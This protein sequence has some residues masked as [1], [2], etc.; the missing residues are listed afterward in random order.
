MFMEMAGHLHALAALIPV[1]CPSL[2]TEYEGGMG[3][4]GGWK[5]PQKR[6]IACLA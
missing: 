3:P 4:G 5:V 6:D 2:P 1:I